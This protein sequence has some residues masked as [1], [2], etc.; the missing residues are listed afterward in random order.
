MSGNPPFHERK[1]GRFDVLPTYDVAS[2]IFLTFESW[3]AMK[4]FCD[5][6]PN[7]TSPIPIASDAE[8]L[9]DINTVIIKHFPGDVLLDK[10]MEEGLLHKTKNGYLAEPCLQFLVSAINSVMNS[11]DMKGLKVNGKLAFTDICMSPG[12]NN[13]GGDHNTEALQTLTT[14][15]IIDFIKERPNLKKIVV[16]GKKPNIWAIDKLLPPRLKQE[17]LDHLFH[18]S[19]REGSEKFYSHC[20]FLCHSQFFLMQLNTKSIPWI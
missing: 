12:P 20:A 5:K 3:K 16:F 11:P 18:E 17:N 1:G 6:H 13:S 15:V 14:E 7:H 19:F 2:T 10:M 8:C 4:A 9:E